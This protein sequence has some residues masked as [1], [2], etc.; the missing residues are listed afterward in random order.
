MVP[1]EVINLLG[2]KQIPLDGRLDLS[3]LD[4]PLNS[5]FSMV[6]KWKN[7]RGTIGSRN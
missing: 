3:G 5:R 6:R 1:D 7:K 2:K 4:I